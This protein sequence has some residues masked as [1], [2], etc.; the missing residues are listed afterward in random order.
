MD[1]AEIWFLLYWFQTL[2]LFIRNANVK[3]K[4]FSKNKKQRILPFR[5]ETFSKIRNPFSQKL[6][7]GSIWNIVS[8]VPL[9]PSFHSIYQEFKR[10]RNIFAKNWKNGE[11][12]S[13]ALKI[14]QISKSIFLKTTRLIQLKYSFLCSPVSKL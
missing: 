1:P 9:V 10:I 2:T 5:F 7:V 11:Y 12:S 14:F 4:P 3:H 8:C 6:S 13:S